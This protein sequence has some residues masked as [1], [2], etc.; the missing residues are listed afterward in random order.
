MWLPTAPS[1]NEA[2]M[3]HKIANADRRIAGLNLGQTFRVYSFS[4]Q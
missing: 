3:L 2:L 1:V 4:K